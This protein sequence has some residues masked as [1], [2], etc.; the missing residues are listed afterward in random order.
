[1][2]QSPTAIWR[3]WEENAQAPFEPPLIQM[4]TSTGHS[5]LIPHGSTEYSGDLCTLDLRAATQ[6]H[7]CHSAFQSRQHQTVVTDA[8]RLG[9]LALLRVPSD[10]AVP[11]GV[12]FLISLP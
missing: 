8:R 12:G 11:T 2:L 10:Q 6:F 3:R 7:G 4:L 1:M 5:G 9:V